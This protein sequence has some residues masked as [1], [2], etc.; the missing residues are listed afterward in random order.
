MSSVH[1]D[2]RE[3]DLCWVCKTPFGRKSRGDEQMGSPLGGAF[4]SPKCATCTTLQA[5]TEAQASRMVMN[6]GVEACRERDQIGSDQ[7]RS[8]VHVYAEGRH[9]TFEHWLE[10]SRPAE[11]EAAW[12]AWEKD[13]TLPLPE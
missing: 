4:S 12:L 10:T 13:R 11:M 1:G 6:R 9:V 7:G 8:P 2:T 5:T 3:G